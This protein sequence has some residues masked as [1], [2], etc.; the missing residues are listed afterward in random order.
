MKVNDFWLGLT[1]VSAITKTPLQVH[2]DPP[3]EEWSPK[4]L[5]VMIRERK[6]LFRVCHK[7]GN[8]RI[9]LPAL[10][11]EISADGHRAVDS[12]YN[13]IARAVYNLTS[14]AG[15]TGAATAQSLRCS[16]QFD[17]QVTLKTLVLFV[18]KK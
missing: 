12:L 10:E 16:T 9:V 7:S 11:F 6:D 13:H 15:P 2:P 1:V 17:G 18:I 3:R 4:K 8:A 14:H 5:E